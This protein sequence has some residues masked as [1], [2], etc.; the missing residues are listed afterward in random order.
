MQSDFNWQW[1][2]PFFLF[3]PLT[4]TYLVLSKTLI[5]VDFIVGRLS[6]YGTASF[7]LTILV[8]VLYYVFDSAALNH[9]AHAVRF[10][11]IIFTLFLVSFYLREYID[12]R[13]RD[14]LFPKRKD[15]Q[16]SVNR[17]L[18]VALP[19]YRQFDLARVLDQELAHNLPVQQVHLIRADEQGHPSAP[20]DAEAQ[21][22]WLSQVP[23]TG[24]LSELCAND[25]GFSTLLFSDRSHC[26]YVAGVWKQPRVWLNIDEQLW[27]GTMLSNARIIIENAHK[28]EELIHLID[29][30]LQQAYQLPGV[31][32][33]ALFHVSERERRRLAHD[34]HDTNVQDQLALAREIDI[35]IDQSANEA[36]NKELAKLRDDVLH[37]VRELRGVLTQLYPEVLQTATL[38]GALLQ[39][40]QY[41]GSRATFAVH[42][43]VDRLLDC[44]DIDTKTSIYR[45]VQ[46]LLNNA[47]KHAQARHVTVIVSVREDIVELIYDDD[48]VGVNAQTMLHS[49][50]TM[51]IPG[52]VGR[53]ESA[54]GSISI[55]SN[56]EQGDHRGFHVA[57]RWPLV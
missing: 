9:P 42:H 4:L 45:I 16:E 18:R 28:A 39:L 34:L 56:R 33:R 29:Q 53:V 6:Y 38:G 26:Y 14:R 22:Q 52:I 13:L 57:V 2:T 25:F 10:S 17:L 46:E 55:Q 19:G 31:V 37:N 5:D 15:Y 3:I 35:K 12:F 32:K 24:R 48:G 50:G 27:L 23:K 47:M 43:Y 44:D 11:L 1:T 8:S 40:I 20:D 30:P 21:L 51:G 54:G 49:F 36:L 7:V 41:V